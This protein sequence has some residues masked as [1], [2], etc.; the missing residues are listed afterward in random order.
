[1]RVYVAFDW[2]NDRNYKFMLNAWHAN[3]NFTFSWDDYSSQEIKTD[4][5]GRVKA[6]LAAKINQAT[7]TLVLVGRYANTR[8]KDA[9]LIGYPNWINFEVAKSR[10]CSN[11]LVAVSLE[12]SNSWP[13][14]LKNAGASWARAFTQEAVEEALR[15]A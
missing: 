1:M 13:E 4:D 6:A 7:H 9:G 15:N 11:K 12:A 3:P 5:V 10:D 8:H 2:E 14:E